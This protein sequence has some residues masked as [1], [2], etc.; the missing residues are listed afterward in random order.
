MTDDTNEVGGGVP[1]AGDGGEPGPQPEAAAS[2]EPTG[3]ARSRMESRQA[4]W[5]R[6]L[7]TMID[8]VA[9]Q[10]A[11]VI[12]EVATK[13]SE[14]AQRAAAASAPYA[15]KAADVTAD[16]AEAAAQKS[17]EV[18]ADLRR[19]SAAQAAATEIATGEP[20]DGAAEAAP[21]ADEGGAI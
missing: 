6:Q 14:L 19:S 11:P 1:A 15:A 8:E 20:G 16:V 7:Q 21:S 4:E 3:D 12:R 9:T 17:R 10:A 2:T 13:A 18:A 5:M